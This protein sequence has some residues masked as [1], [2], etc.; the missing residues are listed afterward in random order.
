MKIAHVVT[1]LSDDHAFGGPLSVARAQTRELVRRG[2]RV[3]LL[4]GWDG[5][6]HLDLPGVTVRTFPVRQAVPRTGFSGL[7]APGLHAALTTPGAYDVVH[8]HLAR[9]LIT[10]PAA[11]RAL[12]RKI[13]YVLQPHGMVMPDPR[14]RARVTDRLATRS[15]LS[16]AAR[17]LAL[18]EVEAD[19]LASLSGQALP[20]TRLANGLPYAPPSDADPGGTSAQRAA[21]GGPEVLFLARLHPRKRVLAF[22]AMAQILIERGVAARFSVAGPDEGELAALRAEIQDRGLSEH[23]TYE[24]PVATDDVPARLAS[25][26]VYVLP[27][28]H[29]PF[30]MTVL[31]A[32]SAGTPTVVTD[33][34]HISGILDKHGAA[35]VTDGSP[36]ALADAVERLLREPGTV[37][38]LRDGGRR[39][40]AAEFSITAVADQLEEIYASAIAEN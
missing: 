6:G 19:G 39:A 35:L 22:A 18:T 30:P 26:A 31:E 40:L 12:A 1:Y 21:S 24:G 37:A 38:Q 8:I 14:L 27:S 16:G 13:P 23:L 5:V 3:D 2:H 20:L 4:T 25:A 15:V 9:D 17:V 28:V 11:R 36:V 7:V 33:T 32:L 10:L 34:C 29:E